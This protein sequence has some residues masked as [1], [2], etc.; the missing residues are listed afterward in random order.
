M[1]GLCVR[2]FARI[3]NRPHDPIYLVRF[4]A[5]P[6]TCLEITGCPARHKARALRSELLLPQQRSREPRWNSKIRTAETCEY[7]E[8][9]SDYFAVGVQ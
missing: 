1:P 3:R 7:G 6:Q 4:L 8:C 2:D 9:D 5:E